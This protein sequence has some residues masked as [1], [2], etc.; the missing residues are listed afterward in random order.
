L[1]AHGAKL[2]INADDDLTPVFLASQFGH[3]ECLRTLLHVAR[4]KGSIK[5]LIFVYDLSPL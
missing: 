1:V 2:D 3:K 4:E 5:I